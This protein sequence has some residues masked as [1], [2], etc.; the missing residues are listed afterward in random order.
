MGYTTYL[1]SNS[2]MAYSGFIQIIFDTIPFV[3]R[4]SV[5]SSL[6]SPSLMPRART[7]RFKFISN[8]HAQN[9]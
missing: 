9:Q 2:I 7:D 8:H 6:V 5:I 3:F 1:Q 4:T